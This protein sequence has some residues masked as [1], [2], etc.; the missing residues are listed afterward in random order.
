MLQPELASLKHRTSS[1]HWLPTHQQCQ[2][3]LLKIPPQ[4]GGSLGDVKPSL[5]S[6]GPLG[7]YYSCRCTNL[8]WRLCCC[9]TAH[10]HNSKLKSRG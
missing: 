8:C 9:H 3:V 10:L 7:L 2:F 4:A 6:A 1:L 5:C